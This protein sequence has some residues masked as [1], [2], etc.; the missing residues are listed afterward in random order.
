MSTR[1]RQFNGGDLKSFSTL[2][3]FPSITPPFVLVDN[4]NPTQPSFH[5]PTTW[6]VSSILICIICGG[7]NRRV[8]RLESN[9]ASPQPGLRMTYRP[10]RF[11]FL[12]NQLCEQNVS[13]PDLVCVGTSLGRSPAPG[14]T[15]REYVTIFRSWP[16]S[17]VPSM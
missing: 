5:P 11:G 9:C 13:H 1:K 16:E 4:P 8:T 15:G 7:G 2:Y 17:P 6:A 10:T 3:L 12:E 14:K